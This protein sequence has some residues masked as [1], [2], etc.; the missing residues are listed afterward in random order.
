MLTVG[1]VKKLIIHT[2]SPEL[3]LPHHCQANSS[4]DFR[5]LNEK[6]NLLTDISES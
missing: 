6:E 4:P 5:A 3:P 2:E 1:P